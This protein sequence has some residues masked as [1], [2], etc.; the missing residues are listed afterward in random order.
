[1]SEVTGKAFDIKSFKRIMGYLRPYKIMLWA[2]VLLTIILSAL[3]PVNPWLT[4]YTLDN[5]VAK[6]NSHMLVIMALVLFSSLII[7][8]LIQFLNTYYTNLLGQNIIRD[9]RIALYAHILKLKLQFYDHTPIGTLVTRVISD[10]ETIAD[11]FSEGLI[12][13]V[14]QLLI[15]VVVVVIMFVKDAAMA[16]LCLSVFP[17]LLFATYLF[18]KY[19]Q[20]SFQEVRTQVAK[21]NAFEQEHITGMSVVQIFNREDVELEKFKQINNAHKIANVKSIWYYSIFFPVVDLLS[22]IAIAAIVWWGGRGIL[23]HQESFGTVVEFI[24][25]INMLF[26]PIRQLADR[27]N[28]LQM[29]VVSSQR[30]FKVFDTQSFIEDKGTLAPPS[31]QGQLSFKNVWFAYNDE[32]W[33][34]KDVSFEVKPGQ[35]IAI[36]GATGAGK[37]SIINILGRYYEFQKGSILMDNADI[38]NYKVESVRKNIAIVLQD[39]FLFSDTIANN[40]ALYNN[41]ITT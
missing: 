27:F 28:T 7:K 2:S 9:M 32:N 37:S 19:T 30:I 15:V 16:G 17:I 21:L 18:Q 25:Y 26:I 33:V 1:M 22:A 23:F 41:M 5:Y 3:A 4:Q 29:G 39:V 24:M 14:N 20:I 34:L 6:G 36:V 8:G 12:V 10:I 31:L 11:V 13:M 38:R 35:T 40:I